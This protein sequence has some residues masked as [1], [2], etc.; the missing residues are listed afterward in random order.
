MAD[1]NVE[2]KSPSIWPWILGLLV[3]AL[4]IWAIAEAFDTDEPVAVAPEVQP[5]T[6]GEPPEPVAQAEGVP[7]SQII[8]SPATWTGRTVTGE[9]RVA[10]VISDRGFFITDQGERLF[11]VISEPPGETINIQ[12]GQ[13]VRLREA[14]VLDVNAPQ[15]R[16]LPSGG[17]DAE[18]QRTLEQQPVALLVDARNINILGQPGA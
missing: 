16:N 7:V 17:I 14:T 9:V 13:T 12:P 5:T 2:R 3:L 18:T 6:V 1:I 8:E 11:V 15:L 4:L 10:Q